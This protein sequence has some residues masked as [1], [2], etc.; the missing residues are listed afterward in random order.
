MEADA[1]FSAE[2]C[3]RQD[4]ALVI[5]FMALAAAQCEDPKL[6]CLPSSPSLSLT[7]KGITFT[8]VTRSTHL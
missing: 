5:N 8:D 1:L 6:L 7:L 4:Q 3:S 2:E